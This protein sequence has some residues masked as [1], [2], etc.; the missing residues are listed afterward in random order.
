MPH[1]ACPPVPEQ[2]SGQFS[3]NYVFQ[4]TP[5]TPNWWGT[6]NITNIPADSVG[7]LVAQ[8]WKI[9]GITFD[10][11]TVPPTPYYAMTRETLKN[12]II[13]Q[14]LLEA[15]TDQTNV[16]NTNNTIRYN[17][18]ITS[19]DIMLETSH[20]QFEAQSHEHV[21]H[22]TLYLSDTE[23]YMNEVDALIDL[24][25]SQLLLDTDDASDK[26]TEM[27]TKLSDLET[28]VV[29]STATIDA[30]LVTQ[31]GYL[32]TF[33]AD[34]AAK[35][36]DLDT[37][38][39]TQL[40]AINLLLTQG[41][42]DLATF[43]ASQTVHLDA[44]EL[45][46]ADYAA[47]LDS[48]L[49]SANADILSVTTE[50]DNV[51]DALEGE[52]D[53]MEAEV[54]ALLV[55]GTAAL[56]TFATDYGTTLDQLTT[57]YTA[58]ATPLDA[59]RV[60]SNNAL[61]GFVTDYEGELSNLQPE[62]ATHS[63]TATAFLVDLGATDLARINEQFDAT[64]SEQLQMLTDRGLYTSA[65]AADITARNTRD[66]DEQITAL[67]DR[68]MR[69]KLENQHGLYGQQV[70]MRD[71][72][73]NGF[74]RVNATKQEVLRS[75][76]AQLTSRFTLQQ[77]ARDRT[78]SGTDRL[79]SAQQE[80]WQYQAATITGQ[81]QLQLG[82]RDRT[83]TGQQSLYAL[84]EA[85]TRLNT[86]IQAQLYDATRNIKQLLTEEAA[87]LQ[88]LRQS[89]T[90]WNAGQRDSLFAQLQQIEAQHLTGIDKQNATSQDVSRVAM[91]ERE[92]LLGFLQDAV[93]GVISGKGTYSQM[94]VQHG[95]TLAEH[96]HRAIAEKMN[97]SSQRLA[98]LQMTHEECLKLMWDQLKERN[99]ILV[100]LYGFV[101]RRDD[102][103]PNFEALVQITTGLGDAG[104]G[105][106]T[107]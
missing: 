2:D 54:D 39:A 30:L 7:W 14:S 84:R 48:L 22:S 58:I 81:Y 50:I 1:I 94:T 77:S 70:A 78:M 98:S 5:Y 71:R 25:Q 92:R 35:L 61:S 12:W 72:N 100:G 3:I 80:V 38:Y 86:T 82:V 101:E 60:A 55:L 27:H 95:S 42:T 20:D 32:T 76:V 83:I 31:S 10:D 107:P 37:D 16:A 62:Y 91:S 90:L 87:R 46:Y 26:L 45:E 23:A 9:T 21:T 99:N 15:Y 103:P 57:D 68:L 69:E 106:V 102:I 97:E 51:L 104:G 105:W 40:A 65:V 79:N 75:N 67:N 19:W 63:D 66:R 41:D 73:L 24:N 49:I 64:L 88:N 4:T 74:D 29:S 44:L 59:E 28:N 17:D 36:A 47:E 6:D 89:V 53:A 8:G 11:T 34:L 85:N 13:L 43:A 56:T 52:Y 93:N 18:I 96:K 33:L